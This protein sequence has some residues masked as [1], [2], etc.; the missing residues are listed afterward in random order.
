MALHTTRVGV[1]A[2]NATRFTDQDYALVSRAQIDTIKMM[3]MTEP[4]VYDRL[5]QSRP[6]IEFIVRLYDDRLNETSRPSPAEFVS[7]M[8]P[9]IQTLRRYTD[10]FEIHNEPN[11]V[12]RIEG[13]GS[14]D[15]NARSFRV[16]YQEV[17]SR[18]KAACPWAKFGFPGLALNAPHRDLPWLEICKQ[19]IQASDWLGC[20]CYWQGGNM[21][22][23]QWGLRFKLYHDRF[24]DKLIEITEFGNSTP[25]VPAETMAQQYVQYYTEL[26]R[27]P[28]LGSASA[29]IASSSD[30]QWAPFVWAKEG[31]ELL[32]VVHA[33]GNMER[34]AVEVP[35]WP[36]VPKPITPPVTPPPV[37]P[38]PV[39]PPPII[40]A[41]I[42]EPAEP[43]ERVFAETGK[44]VSGSF[45][46]FFDQYGVDICGWPITDQ[47]EEVGRPAQYFQRVGLEELKNGTIRLKLVGTEAWEARPQIAT[48]QEQIRQLTE[49]CQN[50]RSGGGADQQVIAALRAEN[51]GLQAEAAALKAELE[52]LRQ[53]GTTPPTLAIQNITADL[54]SDPAHPYPTRAL[55]EIKQVV[56]HHTGTTATITPQRLADAQVHQRKKPGIAFHYFIGPDGTIFQTNKLETASDHAADRSRQ[57]VGIVFPGD[58]TTLIPTAEQLQ[59]AGRLVAWLLQTLGLD[60]GSIVGV[61]E[62]VATQS[63]GKQWLT[64]QRW[65]D[66][67]LAEVVAAQ[68]AA[69]EPPP[70]DQAALIAALRAE[71]ARLEAGTAALQAEID[72]LR[73]QPAPVIVPPPAP[74]PGETPPGDGKVAR[75]AVQDMIARLPVHATKRYKTRRLQDIRAVIVHHSA[76]PPSVGPQR[77]AEYH[78]TKQ[79]WPGIGYHFLVGADGTIYQGEAVDT[80]SYHAVQANPYGVGVCFLGNFTNDIPPAPQLE[81]GAQLIAWLMQE[82]NIPLDNVKGHREVVATACPGNQ[83]MSGKKW[84]T[85]LRQQIV[86]VQQAAVEPPPAA[87]PPGGDGKRLSHY[88]LFWQRADTWPQKDW[89]NAQTYIGAFRP[90]AGFSVDEALLARYVTI[91]GGPLGTS[92][93]TEN[94]LR[95]AGCRVDRIDGKDEADTKRIL[96]DLAARGKRFLSFEG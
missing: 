72:R 10:K 34:R 18:L 24:P 45:L 1:H 36:T 53:Q 15:E 71:I 94:S 39:T 78:V 40:P 29:F 58:F 65:K 33:V 92:R 50:L 23:D 90:T 30:P 86:R 22:S 13:W 42:P 91:V 54:P 43:R 4:A 69:V 95:A 44:T 63:P 60:A 28:Y 19:E 31:G 79:G 84:K 2:R 88:M 17:L 74:G 12:K 68:A 41:P 46:R 89:D 80:L 75:P 5:R 77:I 16:W 70:V 64:G 67:L 66:K 37:T 59:A 38:P 93:Q 11:H 49:E 55:D 61:G 7:R 35:A 87:V 6:G 85:V 83:W 8:V 57:S 14:S 48:L 32:P 27:Y 96:D 26:H 3:S 52:R 47:I 73:Q 51:A 81:A 62:F 21:M 76:V 9:I 25:N 82:L 20:H 56:I